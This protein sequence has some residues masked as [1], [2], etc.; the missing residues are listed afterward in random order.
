MVP[1][2]TGPRS[3]RTTTRGTPA[4]LVAGGQVRDRRVAAADERAPKGEMSLVGPRPQ[5]VWTTW[6]ATT[7]W[8][9]VCFWP[10]PG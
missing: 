5:P 10:S 3:G 8:P 4:E 7:T 6:S 2:Q 9:P 1:R